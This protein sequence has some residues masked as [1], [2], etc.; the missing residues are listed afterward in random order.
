[1][2]D[3]AVTKGAR[4]KICGKNN[5]CNWMP[6]IARAYFG[7]LYISLPIAQKDNPWI[8]RL[9]IANF[10]LHHPAIAVAPPGNIPALIMF[11]SLYYTKKQHFFQLFIS[12]I[13]IGRVPDV[14]H[15]LCEATENVKNCSRVCIYIRAEVKRQRRSQ[16]IYAYPISAYCK[17][18]FSV[19]ANYTHI[20]IYEYSAKKNNFI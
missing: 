6:T 11:S 20:F 1:M 13:K 18:D 3:Y 17:M 7:V 16:Y 15:K 12:P 14:L 10:W 8:T 2:K 19:V 4:P 9:K 5:P